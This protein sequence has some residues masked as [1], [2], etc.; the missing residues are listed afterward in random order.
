[1]LMNSHNETVVDQF[2]RQADVFAAAGPIRT[3]SALGLLVSAC[4][5]GR[6]DRALDV[7]CGP[8]LVAC[9]FAQVVHSVVGIDLTPAMLEKAR[10]LAAAKD[11]A[12]VSFRTGDVNSLPFDA[13]SFSIVTSRYAF[14]HFQQPVR[15]LREMARVSRPG[16]RVAVMDMIASDVPAKAALFNHMEKLR[17]PS[18]AKALTHAAMLDCFREARLSAPAI[19]P[20]KMTVELEGLLK[21]SF[22]DG[23]DGEAVRKLVV[24][25]LENNS[26]GV[27]TVTKDGRIYFSYPIAVYVARMT[28]SE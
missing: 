9:A 21:A 1:M 16:G 15:V 18:H 2:T 7:A 17:D 11:L 6:D 8:G 26:M 22:P 14:H 10:E 5:A 24:A 12:N 19:T 4:E 28:G 25:S 20:Y 3:E 23:S 13:G 27:D